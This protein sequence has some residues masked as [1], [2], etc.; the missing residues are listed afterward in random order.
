MQRKV[1][2][3]VKGVEKSAFKSHEEIFK[4]IFAISSSTMRKGA[5][6]MTSNSHVVVVEFTLMPS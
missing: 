3:R 1:S 4:A 6:V 5:V 2:L